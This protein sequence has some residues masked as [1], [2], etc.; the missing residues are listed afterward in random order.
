MVFFCLCF[1][2]LYQLGIGGCI[3]F[4]MPHQILIIW[5]SAGP[6]GCFSWN[7]HQM[8]VIM[9][10]GIWTKIVKMTRVVKC[11][12]KFSRLDYLFGLFQI[13]HPMVKMVI[14]MVKFMTY[15][16]NYNNQFLAL[17]ANVDHT[18]ES[19]HISYI[20]LKLY[21]VRY[22][23]IIFNSLNCMQKDSYIIIQH[24]YLVN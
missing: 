3:T 22:V 19:E 4:R 15:F 20:F 1:Y 5:L 7:N 8:V 18:I 12:V 9:W 13:N 10:M 2:L 11:T 17:L 14:Y 21:I 16:V 23:C 24:Y 6:D